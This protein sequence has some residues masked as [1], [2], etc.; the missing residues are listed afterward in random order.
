MK[1]RIVAFAGKQFIREGIRTVTMD[2]IAKDMGISKRTLYQHFG[3]K[4]ALLAA[5]IH[6][7]FIHSNLLV[8]CNDNLLDE[9]FKLQTGLCKIDTMGFSRFYRELR[10]HYKRVYEDLLAYMYLYAQACGAKTEKAVSDGYV[11]KGIDARTIFILVSAC[12]MQLFNHTDINNQEQNEQLLP[13]FTSLAIRGLCTSEGQVYL[14]QKKM[15]Q[16]G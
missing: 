9:L 13:T 12:V 4:E 8:A 16:H 7:L 15:I 5:C 2:M 10:C 6:R 3:C 11:R 14:D 1:G